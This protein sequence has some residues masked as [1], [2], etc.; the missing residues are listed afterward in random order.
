MGVQTN[1]EH[2]GKY[3]DHNAFHKI[4]KISN[5]LSLFLEDFIISNLLLMKNKL[6]H[7]GYCWNNRCQIKHYTRRDKLKVKL[8]YV[9]RLRTFNSLQNSNCL[10]I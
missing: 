5:I 3:D 10:K 2:L 4:T 9:L 7:K 8:T 6:L 1:H